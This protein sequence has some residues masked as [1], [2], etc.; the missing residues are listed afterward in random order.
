MPVAPD[1]VDDAVQAGWQAILG[2][3]GPVI[4]PPS[5]PLL[6]ILTLSPLD[7]ARLTVFREWI[8]AIIGASVIP[9]IGGLD[10]NQP[11]VEP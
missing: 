9:P 1:P 6:P 2:Q 7:F 3:P 8:D 4:L 10:P 5:V 11:G